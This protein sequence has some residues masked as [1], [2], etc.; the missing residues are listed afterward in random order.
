MSVEENQ[1]IEK[2][3]EEAC[4]VRL[5]AFVETQRGRLGGADFERFYA[6]LVERFEELQVELR[7]KIDGAQR[8]AWVHARMDEAIESARP[9]SESCRVGCSGCCHLKVE[10]TEEE[11]EVLVLVVEATGGLMDAGRLEAQARLLRAGKE[12]GKEPGAPDACAFLSEDQR[13]R[14]YAARPMACRRLLVRSQPELCWDPR[15]EVQPVEILEV[16]LVMSA[17]LSLSGSRVGALPEL[18]WEAFQRH[19]GARDGWKEQD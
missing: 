19:R 12:W 9:F 8:V 17:A 7:S 2:G 1:G 6:S 14:V 18:V 15:G 3:F 4:T 5:R 16:E 13:C 11:A 10:I